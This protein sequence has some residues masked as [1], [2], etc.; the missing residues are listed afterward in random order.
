MQNAKGEGENLAGRFNSYQQ[1]NN[2]GSNPQIAD[3]R[4]F[5][6]FTVSRQ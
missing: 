4:G 5:F 2:D 6:K 1:L 3:A